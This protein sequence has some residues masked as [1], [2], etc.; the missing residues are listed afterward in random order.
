MVSRLV[1]AVDTRLARTIPRGRALTGQAQGC[2]DPLPSRHDH[3][4]EELRLRAYG[5]RQESEQPRGLVRKA[6]E[7]R[8]VQSRLPL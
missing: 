5:L 8:R 2:R 3:H 4:R 6:G 1:E 7:M